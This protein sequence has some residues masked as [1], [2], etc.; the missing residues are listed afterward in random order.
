MERQ[1]QSEN[2]TRPVT[3]AKCVLTPSTEETEKQL[4]AG[5]CCCCCRPRCSV[6]LIDSSDRMR[7]REA[8]P[9]F[10]SGRKRYQ[11]LLLI[12][13]RRLIRNKTTG[14]S[15]SH[16]N[17]TQKTS[18][19]EDDVSVAHACIVYTPTRWAMPTTRRYKSTYLALT[20]FILIV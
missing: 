15:Y 3:G 19:E 9:C 5:T 20:F 10:L 7:G 17:H 14:N 1:R 6:L 11:E 16:R 18:S 2:K 8:L 12:T 4:G 13:V